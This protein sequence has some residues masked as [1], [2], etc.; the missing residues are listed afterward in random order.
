MLMI[1][2]NIHTTIYIY[3]HIVCHKAQQLCQ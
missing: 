1:K 3:A 2:T